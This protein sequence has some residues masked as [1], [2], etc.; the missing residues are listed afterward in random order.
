MSLSRII[1]RLFM[2]PIGLILAL[3]AAGVFL[4]FALLAMDPNFAGPGPDPVFENVF[5]VFTGVFIAGIFGSI[6]FYPILLG[7]IVAEI[8][9]WRS[10]FVY[11]AYGLILSLFAFHAPGER[12]DELAIALDIRAMAAGLVGGFVYWLVAGRGAGIVKRTLTNKPRNL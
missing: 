6:G 10:L 2:V 3:L 11:L 4:G 8:L 5:S 12:V 9:S 1:A 7:L